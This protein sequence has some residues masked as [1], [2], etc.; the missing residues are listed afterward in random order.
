M[1]RRAR[2]GDPIVID[3]DPKI[4]VSDVDRIPIDGAGRRPSSNLDTPSNPHDY[5]Q[6]GASHRNLDTPFSGSSPSLV[7]DQPPQ[8]HNI[9]SSPNPHILHSSSTVP[10]TSP[11]PVST[12]P[13]RPSDGHIST[14]NDAIPTPPGPS[15]SDSAF[16]AE[17]ARF[18]RRLYDRNAPVHEIAELMQAMRAREEANSRMMAHSGP[19]VVPDICPPA[20]DFSE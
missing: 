1:Q 17:E 6:D 9:S 15:S 11:P 7:T 2:R 12:L 8:S 4:L 20:Y 10:S 18:L 13:S 16:A 3:P 14:V 5:I 19:E